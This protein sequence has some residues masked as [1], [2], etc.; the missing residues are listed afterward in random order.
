MFSIPGLNTSS[1][2][3]IFQLNFSLH[4]NVLEFFAIWGFVTPPGYFRT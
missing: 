1:T 4:K 2:L 3:N